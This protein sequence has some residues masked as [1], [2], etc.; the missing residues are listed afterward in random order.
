MTNNNWY[1]ITGGPSVGKTSLLSELA[2]LGYDVVPEAARTVIDEGLEHG[3]SL[4]TI[5]ADEK[6]FQEEVAVRK[7]HIEAARDP[8]RLTFFDRGMQDTV[9]YMQY[10]DFVINPEIEKMMK[11]SSYK[12]VF[13]LEPL[14]AYKADYARTEDKTFMKEVHDLLLEAY[15]NA[16]MNPILVPD[17]GIKERL[18]IILN[19]INSTDQ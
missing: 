7:Q 11:T 8:K 15:T 14:A 19:E 3:M 4:S 10:Y 9:A 16:G 17:I 1:V 5:R 6:K 2:K 13:L 18:K 12:K